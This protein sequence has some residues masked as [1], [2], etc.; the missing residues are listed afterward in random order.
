MPETMAD[1]RRATQMKVMCWDRSGFCI[2]QIYV[3]FID[4]LFQEQDTKD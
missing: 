3:N 1:N 4:K 2:C